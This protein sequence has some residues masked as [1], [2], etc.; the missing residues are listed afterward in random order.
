MDVAGTDV[1]FIKGAAK[2]VAMATGNGLFGSGPN[3]LRVEICR[4]RPLHKYFIMNYVGA[5]KL[6]LLRIG[7]LACV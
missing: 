3:A 5:V 2:T 4:P 6:I 1:H 7:G